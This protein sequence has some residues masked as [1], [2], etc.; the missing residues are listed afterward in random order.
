MRLILGRVSVVV[1]LAICLSFVVL[2]WMAGPAQSWGSDSVDPAA[3]K[4]A[5]KF[6]T[7]PAR[8][9]DIHSAVHFGT[10]LR[11]TQFVDARGIK[12]NGK[13]VPDEFA[14]VYRYH[15]DNDGV[16]DIGFL[17]DKNGNV[18]EVEVIKCNGDFQRPYV[19]ANVSI[20]LVGELLFEAIKDNMDADQR[21]I[22]RLL[23]EEADAKG[24]MLFSLKLQQALGQ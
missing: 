16:T 6:L 14:L 19:W 9:R 22:M 21:A 4:K 18:F 8:M 17:C 10:T 11:K 7:Q 2:G 1:K 5:E 13:I 15:W 24:L 3:V 12:R 20:K 23:I